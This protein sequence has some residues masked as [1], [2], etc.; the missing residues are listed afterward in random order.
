LQLKKQ[1]KISFGKEWVDYLNTREEG[2][3]VK[4]RMMLTQKG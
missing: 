4:I 3:L 2:K 1:Q